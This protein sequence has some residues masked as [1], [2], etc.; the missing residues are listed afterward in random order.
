MKI[1]END[2]HQFINILTAV[3]KTHRNNIE[4]NLDN[5]RTKERYV[6]NLDIDCYPIKIYVNKNTITY[7]SPEVDEDVEIKNDDGPAKDLWDLL[8]EILSENLLYGIKSKKVRSNEQTK[9][10]F[11]DTD[12]VLNNELMTYEKDYE[13]K[14]AYE[15]DDKCV[16]LLNDLTDE[17]NAKIVISSTWR[18]SLEFNDLKVVLKDK[19]ITGDV[20][21]ITPILNNDCFRGNEIYKWIKE[22]D[23]ML[24]C[25]YYEYNNYVIL[26][27]DS[28]M[29]YWQRNNFI[30]VDGWCG[31]TPNIIHRAERLLNR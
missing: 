7:S 16:K 29:L 27:D 19:G 8:V 2:Q 25:N 28:D 12:G 14:S 18:M 5:T 31:L 17:T 20:I 1:T 4:V 9:I 11:L 3:V 13:Q 24:G 22:N 26:D 23:H 30:L 10:I 15:V 21:G 6:L